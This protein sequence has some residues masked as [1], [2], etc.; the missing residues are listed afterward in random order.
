MYSQDIADKVC[1]LIASGKSLR[2]IAAIEG[3]PSPSTVMDWARNRFGDSP[4]FSAQYA[5]AMDLRTDL[6]A[7]ELI[8][9]ADGDG[10]DI[11]INEEGGITIRPEVVQRDRLRVDTRKWVLSKLK[12]KV[13]G[14]KQQMDVTTNGESINSISDADLDRRIAELEARKAASA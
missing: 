10:T 14:D 6:L 12:P 1:E 8:E 13:Y 2:Q 9:I 7:E 4:N 5:H 3:M 11:S